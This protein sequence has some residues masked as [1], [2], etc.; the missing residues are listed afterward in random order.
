MPKPKCPDWIHDA[1]FYEIY[2]QTFY[3][4]N[5][6]GIGDLP[7][8]IEKLDYVKSLGVNAIWLNPFYVSP[9]RDAGYDVADF[10]KVD[11]RYGTNNDAKRLFK[12]AHKRGLRVIIDFVP[13]HT[14]IDHP[15]FKASCDP[16]PNKYT[17][18]YVWTDN[19]WTGVGDKY[20]SKMIH[21]Y[22]ERNGNYMINFFWSQPA[23]NYGFGKPEADWQLPVNH[24]DVQALWKEMQNVLW[25]WL[26]MGC[27]G[28]RIDMA[29]S[30][31]RNDPGHKG[32]KKFWN[33]VRTVLDK[34]Y[35]EAF[36]VA[37]WSFPKA[38][39][40]A[41]FHADFLHWGHNYHDL[42]RKEKY[43]IPGLKEGAPSFF[44]QEGKGDIS[45]FMQCYLDQYEAT[46]HKGYI[47]IPV[48][49]HDLS[50]INI[51]RS[52][53]D[54]EIIFAFL[55]TMPG[56][57]FMYYGDEI[58][59]RQCPD[60]WPNIEGCYLPRAGARTPMQWNKSKNL[61]FSKAAKN[62]LWLPVDPAKK[63]PTV[64]NQ[65]AKRGSLL[66][67]TREMVRI[68]REEPGLLAH[69]DFTPLYAKK[70]AYPLVYLRS[71]G[72]HRVLVALN[73]SKKPVKVK[74]GLP[75]NAGMPEPLIGRNVAPQ[76]T[77]KSIT[78][79][80]GGQSYGVFRLPEAKKGK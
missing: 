53:K 30:L 33:E 15:W 24:P 60:D 36:I 64:E 57:P 21:G 55:M 73:P 37:E 62:K 65:E 78:L 67:W 39:I 10:Y 76:V 75:Y 25:F 61:G 52:Q 20:A 46:K 49:N 7:G 12:E 66:H 44:D 70:N 69:A 27:D 3:D 68:R 22:C 43:R 1:V 26:D 17:N 5:G 72:K 59:M 77:G 4:T 8:V 74:V 9:M 56:V 41:G 29:G 63:A 40:P 54:L 18:W 11:P 16:K 38:A 47:S 34:K 42:F 45:K 6:D 51:R 14:S 58:G 13:G 80:M 2:P 79:D 32:I 71:Q 28:F 48:G 50:R 31:V 35:P 19:A 23:L